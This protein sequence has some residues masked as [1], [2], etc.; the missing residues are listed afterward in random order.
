MDP[1]LTHSAIED[2]LA[3]YALDAVDGDEALAVEQHLLECAR[4]R[5]EVASYREVAAF[6]AHVGSAA[7][8]GLWQR[9]AANLEEPPPGY[10]LAR[11]VPLDPAS[12]LSSGSPR[13]AGHRSRRMLPVRPVA[14]LAATAAAVIGLLG[15]QLQMQDDRIDRLS[16]AIERRGLDEAV[17]AALFDRASRKVELVSDN[18][19][20]F[21]KAVVQR[22]G[23]GYLVRH[24]LPDLADDM[25]YQLWGL[26]DDHTVSL[27]VLGTSPAVIPFTADADVSVLAV[28]AEPA[29]GVPTTTNAPVVRGFM[30]A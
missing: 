28:T 17:S 13:S 16:P 6:V 7:P 2:L 15:V 8:Q 22:D 20:L 3:V 21:A 25:T 18:G 24:N 29:G 23:R 14:A 12:S 30:P 27:G 19:D 4:C 9:I 10:E 1:K 5:N 26:V 11:V